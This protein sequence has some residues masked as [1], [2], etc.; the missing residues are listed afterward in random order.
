MFLLL[1]PFDFVFANSLSLIAPRR[2]AC[3]LAKLS[4]SVPA[5]NGIEQPTK[6]P[7]LS[8]DSVEGVPVVELT[9]EVERFATFL[10]EALE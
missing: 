3:S 1:A 5:E 9:T 2:T 4:P 8:D 10:S 6:R 7:R